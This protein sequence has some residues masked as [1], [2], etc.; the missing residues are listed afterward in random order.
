MKELIRCEE[1]GKRGVG[2]GGTAGGARATAGAL[3]AVV[4][5]R[6]R[7]LREGWLEG[8]RDSTRRLLEKR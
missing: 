6:R 2:G 4:V 1:R 5:M 8:L 3:V 7:H